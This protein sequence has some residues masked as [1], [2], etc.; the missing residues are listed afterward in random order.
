VTGANLQKAC[1]VVVDL[2]K[3]KADQLDLSSFS[4]ICVRWPLK[5]PIKEIRS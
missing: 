2:C 1:L 3:A 4:A 5:Q